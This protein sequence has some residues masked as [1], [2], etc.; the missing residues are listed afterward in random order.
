M[1]GRQF[2]IGQCNDKSVVMQVYQGYKLL[3][4]LIFSSLIFSI[5]AQQ[6]LDLKWLNPV[7]FPGDTL[8]YPVYEKAEIAIR[9]DKEIPSNTRYDFE[10]FNIQVE[11]RDQEGLLVKKTDGFYL[12]PEDS[13]ADYP[14]RIRFF[15]PQ[16]GLYKVRVRVF[17]RH[18]N[19]RQEVDTEF[20]VKGNPPLPD[21]H[22]YL[23]FRKGSGYLSF[24]DSTSF[25]A[26]GEC[27]HLWANDK[28]EA[29]CCVGYDSKNTRKWA[30]YAISTFTENGGN[31]ARLQM[32]PYAQELEWHQPGVY[33]TFQNRAA[34]LDYIFEYCHKKGLYINLSVFD[35]LITED[36][37]K[38][39]QHFPEKPFNPYLDIKSIASKK[40]LDEQLLA[41][42]TDKTAKDYIK[43]KI[44]Y[45]IARWGYS[46]HLAGIQVNSELEMVNHQT[47]FFWNNTAAVYNWAA[48]MADFVKKTDE[49]LLVSVGGAHYPIGIEKINRPFDFL[50]VHHYAFQATMHRNFNYINNLQV[51]SRLSKA[52][53]VIMEEYGWI[54]Q[55]YHLELK[56]RTTL[57]NVLWGSAFSGAFGPAIPFFSGHEVHLD[58]DQGY[59]KPYFGAFQYRPLSAYFKGEDFVHTSWKP[60]ANFPEW[61]PEKD[62]D[63]HNFAVPDS[64]NNQ[65]YYVNLKDKYYYG[66]IYENLGQHCQLKTADLAKIAFNR[67]IAAIYTDNDRDIEVFALQSESRIIGW[68]HL[69]DFYWK[70]LPHNTALE[71][72][73]APIPGIKDGLL[74]VNQVKDG[75]YLVEWWNTQPALPAAIAGKAMQSLIKTDQLT[76]KNGV[77]KIAIP[78]LCNIELPENEGKCLP[79]YGFKI[80]R[81]KP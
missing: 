4:F 72:T 26:L 1:A 60:I 66:D 36:W 49:R 58:T 62:V 3:L 46:V 59:Q 24:S 20:L 47:L 52:M 79:D 78:D 32:S 40:T 11:I 27:L 17:R 5:R 77:L 76:A 39:Q 73:P 63:Y 2:R 18:R 25:F 44:R 15:L 53:P 56:Y 55:N 71:Y 29:Y 50:S 22:G 68:L 28:G 61:S 64:I 23:G 80:Y 51:Y 14:W 37:Q 13:L 42:F 45:C 21:N 65:V 12:V 57:H 41:F 9:L 81:L 35:H 8:S 31:F 6:I 69:K 75:D 38:P 67:D 7:S 54:D 74:I 43:R 48:E 19:I 10:K 34:D 33:D 30:E 16:P 70:N